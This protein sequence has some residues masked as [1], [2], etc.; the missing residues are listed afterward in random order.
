MRVRILSKY[1]DCLGN[2]ALAAR[3]EKSTFNQV[4]KAARV[5]GVERFW[6]NAIFRKRYITKALSMIFNLDNPATPG[7]KA[8]LLHAQ[9]TASQRQACDAL[10][11]MSPQEMYPELWKDALA[12]VAK[13]RQKNKSK[14]VVQDY[15]GLYKCR[16][17]GSMRTSYT[18]YS[19][20]ER[21]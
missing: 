19:N 21:R 15:D 17:C 9:D 13:R 14:E 2:A 8:G 16:H 7:L 5:D 11:L 12:E 20:Q 3:L 4:V 1:Q 6:E 10:L 18:P